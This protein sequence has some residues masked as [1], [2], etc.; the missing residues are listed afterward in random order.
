MNSDIVL[1]TYATLTADSSSKSILHSVQWFRI[2]LDEGLIRPLY[3]LHQIEAYGEAAHSIRHQ[4][5]KQFRSV[6]TLSA[7]HRWCLTGTPIQNALTDLGALVRFLR[8]PQLDGASDFHSHVA[9]PIEKRSLAGLQRLRALLQCICIRR[10]KD[11]LNL[12][13]PIERIEPINLTDEE[14]NRYRQIGEE[15]R[16]AIDEAINRRNPPDASSGLFRA[17]L[18]LRMFCNTGLFG[19]SVLDCHKEDE[20]LSLLEQGDQAVCT[21]CSC[22]VSSVA[23]K[24]SS[25]SGSFLSC[26]HLLCLD[27]LTQNKTSSRSKNRVRCPVCQAVCSTKKSP[28]DKVSIPTQLSG[29]S[30]KLHA[31][32]QDIVWNRTEKWYTITMPLVS[33]R[34]AD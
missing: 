10:T 25:S 9:G 18:R 33:F 24:D 11:L 5:T 22:D 30:S 14:C 2:I 12:P 15:H 23:E 26:S 19:A 1:T 27:C 31:L 34:K 3:P 17:I 32:A 29:Y 6:V 28:R 8:V 20:G 7:R 4:N 21:Y 16:K 13:E